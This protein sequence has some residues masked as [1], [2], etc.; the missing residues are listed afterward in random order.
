MDFYLFFCDFFRFGETIQ[1]TPSADWAEAQPRGPARPRA[2][3]LLET[4]AAESRSGTRPAAAR[5]P[6]PKAGP[7]PYIPPY[8]AASPSPR[9]RS[10]RRRGAPPEP[11][12]PPPK[13]EPP[14]AAACRPVRR[15]SRRPHPAA[16]RRPRRPARVRRCDAVNK[17]PFV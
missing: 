2:V 8:P 16:P 10:R 13:E 1:K 3:S 17:R 7:P 9:P 11:P 6:L 14:Y 15:P 12:A 4:A 5:R